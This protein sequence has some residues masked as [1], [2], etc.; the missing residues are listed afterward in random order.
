MRVCKAMKVI[1][2]YKV[3]TVQAHEATIEWMNERF[4]SLRSVIIHKVDMIWQKAVFKH[5]QVI[6]FSCAEQSKSEC[7][8]ELM[9]I[10]TSH[11]FDQVTSMFL[12]RME[13]PHMEW[14][15]LVGSSVK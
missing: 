15:Y 2:W 13:P 12:L 6:K 4:I 9:N 1:Q 7:F 11:N 10:C 14:L 5:A 3:P 8:D